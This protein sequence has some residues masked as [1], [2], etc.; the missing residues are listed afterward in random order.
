[1]NS[2]RALACADADAAGGVHELL[3]ARTVA[4]NAT[5][6]VGAS[7]GRGYGPRT[8]GRPSAAIRRCGRLC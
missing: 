4:A 5:V 7:H 6:F 8:W 3:R 1:M 2:L